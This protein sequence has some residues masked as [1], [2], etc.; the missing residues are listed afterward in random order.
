MRWQYEWFNVV[1]DFRVCVVTVDVE[2]LLTAE[3]VYDELTRIDNV[4]YGGVL[5]E[6]QKNLVRL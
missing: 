6:W 3:I 1:S 4:V 5:R 2:Q